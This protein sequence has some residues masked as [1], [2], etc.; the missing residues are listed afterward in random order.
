MASSVDTPATTSP[1]RAQSSVSG[2]PGGDDIDA[3]TRSVPWRQALV[4][5]VVIWASFTGLRGVVA[6]VVEY[7]GKPDHGRLRDGFYGLLTVPATWDSGYYV[8][9]SEFG[10]FGSS[11][12]SE[13]RAFFP[14]CPWRCVSSPS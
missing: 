14:E 13:W 12:P 11:Q 9:V 10:Y 1:P 6:L 5:S 3:A 7:F 4:R 8:S 2:E